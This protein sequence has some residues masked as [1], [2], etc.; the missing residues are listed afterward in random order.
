MLMASRAAWAGP[1]FVTDDPEPVDHRRWEIN[2]AIT[3]NW[4]GGLRSAGI[5]S[6]DINYGVRPNLQ[7]HAQPRFT[8]E[9]ADQTHT[10]LDDTEVGMKYRFV[11]L[12]HGVS[13]NS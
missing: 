3:G 2:S 8:Y 12:Q 6:V 1:P 13:E 11:H 5:P 9:K 10:G 7:M 4:G